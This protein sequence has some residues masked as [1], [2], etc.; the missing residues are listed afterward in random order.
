MTRLKFPEI[1]VMVLALLG[2]LVIVF[3]IG[4]G[5]MLTV[6]GSGHAGTGG[7]VS[8]FSWGI[9]RRLFTLIVFVVLALIVAAAVA[10]WRR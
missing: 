5:L 8:V 4:T 10:L 9:S 3:L 7:G 1:V 6:L 2:G